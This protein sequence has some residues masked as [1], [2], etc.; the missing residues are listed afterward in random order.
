MVGPEDSAAA[1][2]SSFSSF[3]FVDRVGPCRTCTRTGPRS[4]VTA[5]HLAS[6][7]P[8]ARSS[9]PP[10][11]HRL[12]SPPLLSP[13]SPLS[14]LPLVPSR[15]FY[16]V[17]H[18]AS[19]PHRLFPLSLF[20][21]SFFVLPHSFY[22]F[23]LEIIVGIVISIL[24]ECFKKFYVS[25]NILINIKYSIRASIFSFFYFLCRLIGSNYEICNAN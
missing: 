8:S 7:C 4:T 15:R 11:P 6:P 23:L 13:P 3:F 22:N 20:L 16:S 24:I 18:S 10:L 2:C 17:F 21:S 9:Q 14:L 1:G 5:F 19:S 25:I 12:T